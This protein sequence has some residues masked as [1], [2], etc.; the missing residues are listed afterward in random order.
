[1]LTL[2]APPV[3]AAQTRPELATVDACLR[4]RHPDLPA[5]LIGPWSEEPLLVPDHGDIWVLTPVERDPMARD[6]RT[7]LPRLAR[8]RLANLVNRGV[9]FPRL[10]IA[11]QLDPDGPVA[12]LL[13][14]LEHG[15]RLCT[16][17]VAR[18]VAGPLP[19]P[20]QT[21]RAVRAV[22]RVLRQSE[23]IV[24]AA[25]DVLLDPIVFGVVGTSEFTHGQTCLW[26]P[27]AAWRW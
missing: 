22:E 13:P 25:A 8:K 9:D 4:W 6:G 2:N 15:P 18:T 21:A 17:E 23:R 5:P 16:D 14:V 3:L 20:A 10:A 24:A 11:H 7:V 12:T 27:L 1:V 19:P 26:Y